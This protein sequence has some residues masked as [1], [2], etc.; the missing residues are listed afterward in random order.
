MR[1]IPVISNTSKRIQIFLCIFALTLFLSSCETQEDNVVAS[2]GNFESKSYYSSGGFQ[3]YTD[4]AKYCFTSFDA[5]KNQYLKR[6][7]DDDLLTINMHL[8]DFED[9]IK[10]IENGDSS[11]EVVVNY[12]FDRSIIDTEDYIFIDSEEHTW[13][14]GHTS[15]VRYNIYF[16]DTQSNVLYYFHNNI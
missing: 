8:D 15:L 1:S 12:D 6:I 11:N 3:D 13:S 9:W 16:F 10:T 14:D 4:Y 7:Q 5:T 2:L